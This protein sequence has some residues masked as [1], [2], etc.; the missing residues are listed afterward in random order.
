MARDPETQTESN[1]GLAFIVG[2]LV[3]AVIVL[4]F[5]LFSGRDESDDLTVTIEG[6][7]DA[8]E[9]VGDAAEGAADAVEGAA[10]AATGN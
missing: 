9:S 10:D 7:G 8:V 3:V 1:S 4:A 2:G 6:G 5:V